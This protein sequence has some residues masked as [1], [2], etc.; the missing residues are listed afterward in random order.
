[1]LC[2]RSSNDCHHCSVAQP[3]ALIE[4]KAAPA[5]LMSHPL[6]LSVQ[7]GPCSTLQPPLPWGLSPRPF[8]GKARADR[9]QEQKR[10][11]GGFDPCRGV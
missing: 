1:M 5:W 8:L 10:E 9:R 7:G 6:T 3:P 11:K 4:N 2:A